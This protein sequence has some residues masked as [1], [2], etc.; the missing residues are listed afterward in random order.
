MSGRVGPDREAVLFIARFIH[1]ID[2]IDSFDSS[3]ILLNRRS[4]HEPAAAAA[5]A[6][7][8]I[9]G[10]NRAAIHVPIDQ[11]KPLPVDPPNPFLVDPHQVT[12]ATSMRWEGAYHHLSRGTVPAVLTPARM[13]GE[14]SSATPGGRAPCFP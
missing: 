1:S 13:I 12:P 10:G 4:I 8:K 3:F 6:D 9:D 11:R 5:A 14:G 7:C 2:S